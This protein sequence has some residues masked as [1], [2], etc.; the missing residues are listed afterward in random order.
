MTLWRFSDYCTADG[1]NLIQ[2]WYSEQDEAVQ[3]VFDETL[4]TLRVVEDWADPGVMEFK[5][6]TREHRG[7]SEIR[8]DIPVVDPN[9]KKLFKRRFRPV[10]I[11]RPDRR[12]FI[13]LLGCEKS[14]RTYK[15]HNAFGLA[16]AHKEQFEQGKGMICEHT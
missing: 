9:T 5:E 16:L 15:P 10:G 1:K 13:F 8:F 12:E 2:Q 7:L 14:G 6:L 3:A 4:L 11:W